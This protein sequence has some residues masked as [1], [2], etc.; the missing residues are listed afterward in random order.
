MPNFDIDEVFKEIFCAVQDENIK[1]FLQENNVYQNVK[2]WLVTYLNRERFKFNFESYDDKALK[3]SVKKDFLSNCDENE[4]D[5]FVNILKNDK[6]AINNA[7]SREDTRELA[8][9]I[10]DKILYRVNKIVV[11]GKS[12]ENSRIIKVFIDSDINFKGK[13]FSPYVYKA[14]KNKNIELVNKFIHDNPEFFKKSENNTSFD[15]FS[16]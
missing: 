12:I 5:L 14:I 8:M 1:K 6:V 15:S 13:N 16:H 2:K 3:A 7:L 9:K 4:V 10:F 11:C